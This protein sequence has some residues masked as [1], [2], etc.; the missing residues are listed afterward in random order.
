MF[1]TPK[2]KV[3]KWILFAVIVFFTLD[4]VLY[5]VS[6]SRLALV[7]GFQWNPLFSYYFLELM[8][9]A[10]SA[11]LAILAG[12][13][14]LV[15]WILLACGKNKGKACLFGVAIPAMLF[16]FFSSLLSAL[17]LINTP[18]LA[19]QALNLLGNLL[20]LAAAAVP[21]VLTLFWRRRDY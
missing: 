8:L 9:G 17:A 21:F 2:Q 20:M 6:G 3:C 18:D 16:G 14:L 10:P 19:A 4:A 1:D 12:L 15:G 11:Y 7:G 5:T 13:V